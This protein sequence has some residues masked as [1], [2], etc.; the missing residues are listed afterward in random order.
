MTSTDAAG[1]APAPPAPASSAPRRYG[2]RTALMMTASG[3]SANQFAALLGAYRAGAGLSD[4]AVNALL[5]VYAVGLIPGLLAA[6]PLSDRY[7]R[8]P[9]AL[10]ALTLNAVATLLLMFGAGSTLWLAPG[11]LLTGISAGALL[12]A[13]GAW[14]KELSSPPYAPAGAETVAARRSG[15]FVSLG[16]ASGGLAAALIAQW[17]PHPMVLAYLPHLVLAVLARGLAQGSPETWPA[18]ADR[19]AAGVGAAAGAAGLVG[20][21]SGRTA[22][23]TD[24]GR[25]AA[26]PD[27]ARRTRTRTRTRTPLARPGFWRAVLPMAPWVFAGPMVGFA[28]LPGLVDG[29]LRGW[30][31]V[32][33]GVATAVVPGAG[34]AVQP[35]AR[36]LSARSRLL[37]SVAGLLV[38]A[39]GFV[40]AGPA[41]VHQQP[42][43]GLV[44][45][46]VLGAGYGLVLTYGLGTAAAL[47]A[48]AGLARLT[49]YFWSLA[50]LGMFAP[51]LLSTLSGSFPMPRLLAGAA[52]LAVLC[53]AL[54]VLLNRPGNRPGRAG[55]RSGR[56][57]RSRRD[58]APVSGR[59]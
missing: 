26:A 53:C 23:G 55:T 6:A 32:Y 3:W 37:S 22:A 35:L 25:T 5:A 56:S 39:A 52:V 50:Y 33:A 43:L 12:A 20:T 45:G 13:G 24:P 11:R 8:R 46:A 2:L 17:A 1:L 18:A 9:V 38:M 21:G 41:V 14:V 4:A 15:V 51:L 30:E 44:A 58:A 7:G 47:A 48:P 42:V 28:T 59:P 31:V 57:G 10:G 27:S 16:F 49:S 34:V 36:R 40:L 19:A 29:G 54:L